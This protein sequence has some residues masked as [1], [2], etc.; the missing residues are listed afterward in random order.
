MG[1]TVR[2]AG[3]DEAMTNLRIDQQLTNLLTSRVHTIPGSLGFGL[4]GNFMDAPPTA[5]GPRFALELQTA[6]AEY[7]PMIRIDEVDFKPEAGGDME[8]DVHV[9]WRDGYDRTT[10]KPTPYY[11]Y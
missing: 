1:L 3:V 10:G 2:L 5:A 6:V 4:E 9:E 8:M 7:M 11:A